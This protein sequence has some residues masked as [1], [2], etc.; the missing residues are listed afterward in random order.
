MCQSSDRRADKA[1]RDFVLGN[2][3]LF[4]RAMAD[5][6]HLDAMSQ[7]GENAPPLDQKF[8]TLI[9]AIEKHEQLKKQI[10]APPAAQ[11]SAQ[12]WGQR[13]LD[14]ASAGKMDANE[15]TI[16][17]TAA[18]MQHEYENDLDSARTD[19]LPLARGGPSGQHWLQSMPEGGR[20]LDH[21]A[22]TLKLLDANAVEAK[23]RRLDK[24]TS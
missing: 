6:R 8:A 17:D 11:G 22:A 5:A 19:L 24:A 12:L 16:R 1:D 4:L 18:T 20:L 13:I 15:G 9:S 3:K 21:F 23:L 10:Q 14:F 2:A 7:P